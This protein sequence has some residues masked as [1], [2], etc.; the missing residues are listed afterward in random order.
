MADKPTK[1]TG[2]TENISRQLRTPLTDILGMAHLLDD[3]VLET[4]QQ[5]YVQAIMRASHELLVSV[6]NNLDLAQL[7]DDVLG[8]REEFFGVTE[9]LLGMVERLRP[10][11]TAKGLGLSLDLAP[12][13]GTKIHCDKSRLS[14]AVYN[15]TASLIARHTDGTLR[16]A[17]TINQDQWG[18]TLS[19]TITASTHTST[20][21]PSDDAQGDTLEITRRLARL[22][23]G[24][25]TL[26]AEEGQPYCGLLTIRVEMPGEEKDETPPAARILVAEDSR[27]NQRLIGLIL[28]KLGH[29]FELVA[30]GREAVEAVKTSRFDMVLMDLHMPHMDGMTASREIRAL[31]DEITAMVPIIALTADVRPQVP[32][33]ILDAGMDG[34]LNK[35]LDVAKL[36]QTIQDSMNMPRKRKM[37]LVRTA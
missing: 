17:A 4:D 22:M 36:A 30:D 10:S 9:A 14:Q 23:G 5:E 37:A 11:A 31:D 13:I 27:A 15:L 26:G 28:S 24:D 18:D 16:L 33:M 2:H 19:V 35:P 8:V 34:L 7:A 3:T 6:D 21:D 29:E 25:A 12:D 1:N 20:L 32:A